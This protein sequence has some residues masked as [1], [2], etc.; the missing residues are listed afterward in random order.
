MEEEEYLG[1]T[2]KEREHY[3]TNYSLYEQLYNEY[4]SSSFKDQLDS[5]YGRMRFYANA[6][7]LDLFR[8]KIIDLYLAESI[9]NEKD[10][11]FSPST[12]T[13]LMKVSEG[14]ENLSPGASLLGVEYSTRN[15]ASDF[16][17]WWDRAL[18][19]GDFYELFGKKQSP[20]EALGFSCLIKWNL[21][22]IFPI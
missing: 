12:L 20:V 10:S 6:S 22:S 13:T 19:W 15:F 9:R 17:S 16:K 14:V 7:P 2:F 21:K 8:A 5:V 3:T 1:Q 18:E 11:L 4:F